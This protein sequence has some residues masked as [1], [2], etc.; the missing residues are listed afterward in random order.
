MTKAEHYYQS[1]DNQKTEPSLDKKLFSGYEIIV[2]YLHKWGINHL[3]GVSGG[4]I[5]K[6]ISYMNP[7]ISPL[8]PNDQLHFLTIGEYLAGFTPIGHYFA[9]NKISGC[10]TT[11]GGATQLAFCGLSDAKLL[12]IPALYFAALNPSS[13]STL[14]PL[15]DVSENGIDLV[16]Q[17]KAI[18]KDACVVLDAVETI[19][20]KLLAIENL[21]HQS[22]TVVV[23]FYPDLLTKQIRFDLNHNPDKEIKFLPQ[24]DI[25]QLVLFKQLLTK[26]IDKK[27]IILYISYE[28]SRYEGIRELIAAFADLLASPI[29]YSANGVN[30][31]PIN[32]KWNYGHIGLGAN[33]AAHEIWQNLNQDDLVIC[34]GFDPGEFTLC[35]E[36]INAGTVIH[37]TG[38]PSAYGEIEGGF[39]HRV[40]GEYIKLISPI[41]QF[42]STAIQHLKE[43][44]CK[45]VGQ[46]APHN[47]NNRKLKQ[48]SSKGCVDL[49]KFYEK[50]HHGWRENTI[51]FDDTCTALHDRP[52]VLQRPHPH[53]KFYAAQ[54]FSSM[55]NAVGMAAGAKMSN[56]ALHPFVFTGDG[57]WRLFAGSLVELTDFALT[58]FI[59][60]NGGYSW[61]ERGCRIIMPEI[62]N[63]YYHSSLRP[64]DFLMSAESI[65]WNGL[66]VKEDLSNLQDILDFCYNSKRSTI[67]NVKCEL[68]QEVGP[69]PRLEK[70]KSQ[71]QYEA[72]K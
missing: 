50:L 20:S 67:V 16:Q 25:H 8:I 47:L 58:I 4:A 37:L 28:A 32:S 12:N 53:A 62:D 65:G 34:L 61:V 68:L 44:N 46:P 69:N 45:R 9:S 40:K 3:A 29:V 11:T 63:T 39:K 30:A 35:L 15:Q 6:L 22:K 41:N 71:L 23:F 70:F 60:N 19:E 33:D 51:V 5:A 64:I 56:P 31:A 27:R 49:Y 17:T 48:P 13:H 7:N 38:L 18:L 52:Y 42:L 2:H 57:C 43:I 66:E 26:F 55:G 14:C 1:D 54:E 21:L 36:Q 59:I 72:K 24:V 10:V